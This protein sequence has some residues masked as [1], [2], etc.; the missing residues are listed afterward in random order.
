[1]TKLA[2]LGCS[3]HNA[4]VDLRERLAFSPAEAEEALARWRLQFP[5]TEAVLVST[6]N[7]VELY[8][9]SA[10]PQ[11]SPSHGQTA[12]FLA[13]CRGLDP[14]EIFDKLFDHQGED[15]V[16]HLFRVACSL[17]SMV[18]G[19][20]QIVSQVKQ[21]YEMSTRCQATGTLTHLAFQRAFEV[22]KRVATQTRLH[23]N[24]VSVASVAV[25]DFAREIF[26]R[27]DDKQVLVIGAGQ[28]GEETL[29]YL[30]EEGASRIRVVN[31]NFSR[32]SELACRAGGQAVAWEELDEQLVL[33]D[34]VVS[35]TAAPEAI[36]TVS[37]FGPI[38]RRRET[39]PLLILD[40]AIPR[41]FDPAIGKH[42]SEVFLY[43]VDDLTRV[44]QE[45]AHRRRKEQHSASRIVEEETQQFM[46]ELRHRATGPIIRRLQQEAK[47]VGENELQRLFNK[48]PELDDRARDEIRT[49]VHRLTQK[50]LHPPLQSLRG[51]SDHNVPRTLIE[52][53]KTLF[54]LTD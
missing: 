28:T 42:F 45:N 51:E 15:A 17:D 35:T 31:R 9:A 21:A 13:N 37:R 33:A 50:L 16:R 36:M 38:Y 54:K 6:C 39:R 43:D 46:Q 14:G 23:Q 26:E 48:L 19:E 8:T 29:R 52:A 12:E 18:L 22:A 1:M 53:F 40:L 20:P 32:A 25:G 5:Q 4:A 3:H 24:R 34:V 7:R 2:V 11:V 41:D 10:D 49:A 27:F 47:E 30:R 44:C